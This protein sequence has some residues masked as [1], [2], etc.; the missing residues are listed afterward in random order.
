MK[1]SDLLCKN[2]DYTPHEIHALACRVDSGELVPQHVLSQPALLEHCP[3]GS[4]KPLELL[5]R[6]DSLYHAFS[7]LEPLPGGAWPRIHE[8]L[9]A[10]PRTEVGAAAVNSF[11]WFR[12]WLGGQHSG[13]VY[14][15]MRNWA[16]SSQWP[17]PTYA[18]EISVQFQEIARRL[19]P[20]HEASPDDERLTLATLLFGWRGFMGRTAD[21]EPRVREALLQLALGQLRVFREQLRANQTVMLSQERLDLLEASLRVAVFFQS[22]WSGLKELLQA[23]RFSP[24][25]CVTPAL[26]YQPTDGADRALSRIPF[27]LDALIFSFGFTEARTDPDLSRT[28]RAYAAYCADKLDPRKAKKKR[29]AAGGTLLEPSAHWRAAYVHALH[30]L[31]EDL[32]GRTEAVLRAAAT[33]DPSADVRSTAMLVLSRRGSNRKSPIQGLYAANWW[34]RRAHVLELGAPFDP[35]EA[36]KVW[37]R[38][39]YSAKKLHQ[40]NRLPDP[41]A[42]QQ[43]S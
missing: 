2:F 36:R 30:E 26:S 13:E 22:L 27:W 28:R 11:R 6:Q 8:L 24:G 35:A 37:K 21:L 18:Q 42:E 43:S 34:L 10:M 3:D 1:P 41:D 29:D 19:V 25:V 20:L 32:E 12:R 5:G 4:L 31:Q 40:E 14:V 9:F 7:V 38:D 33:T 39:R 16:K 15:S 17:R 23:L